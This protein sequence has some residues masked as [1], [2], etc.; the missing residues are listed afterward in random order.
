MLNSTCASKLSSPLITVGGHDD[1]FV[2][3]ALPSS[4]SPT[5]IIFEIFCGFAVCGCLMTATTYVCQYTG[6]GYLDVDLHIQ[7]AGC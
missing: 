2:S 6:F 7:T 3:Y 5:L 4:D 1:T